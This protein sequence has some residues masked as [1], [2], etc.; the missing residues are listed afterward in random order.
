MN[1]ARLAGL[2][3]LAACAGAPAQVQRYTLD[4]THSFVHFEVLHFGTSTL[5]GRFGPLQGE[6]ELDRQARRGRIQV[7]LQ[8]AIVSTGLPALDARLK[9]PDLLATEQHPQAWFIAERLDLNEHGEPSAAHGELT[10]RG[11]SGG[12]TLR[13]LRFNCYLHPLLK[14][15]VCGG[16]FEGELLRSAYGM[17]FGLP[18]VADRVRLL[19]EVEA[20]EVP[21]ADTAATASAPQGQ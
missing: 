9:A 12:L 16:D 5:R 18:F 19:V 11:T 15:R 1:P 20:L 10:L 4:P 14:R 8:P 3:L 17:N 2:A 7:Q 13:A 21:A 6:V